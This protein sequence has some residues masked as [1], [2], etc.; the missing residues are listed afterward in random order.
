VGI[1]RKFHIGIEILSVAGTR[2]SYKIPAAALKTSLKRKV[3]KCKKKGVLYMGIKKQWKKTAASL[4]VL[5]AL[6]A[7]SACAVQPDGVKDPKYPPLAGEF[8]PTT[9]QQH[10]KSMTNPYAHAR[11]VPFQG[12]ALDVFLQTNM[13]TQI[14]FPAPPVLVNIGRPE[15]FSVEVV[16]EFNSVFVKPNAEVEMTNLIVTTERGIY[17]FILKANPW[18][19]FDI[20]L[21]VTDPYRNVTVD[22]TQTLLWMAYNGVRPP[23]FQF[24]AMEIR[25]IGDSQYVY[26]P[27]T[28]TGLR[29][30]LKRSVALPRA[31]KSVHWIEFANA[32]H[33]DIRSDSNAASFMIDERSVWTPGLVETA[34]P[35]TQTSG[36]PLL[37]KGEKVDM[38]LITNQGEVP[39]QLVVRCM[40]QGGNG[41]FPLEAR[42]A[43]SV[44]K[45]GSAGVTKGGGVVV[46]GAQ[47]VDE[48][49]QK[50]YEEQMKKTNGPV[51]PAPGSAHT[52]VEKTAQGAVP[53]QPAQPAQPVNGA[54]GSQT[55]DKIFFVKP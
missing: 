14:Q 46:P 28:K 26:D 2:A 21:V 30:T 29:A 12:A 33:P 37:G 36:V 15:G 18:K 54:P 32:T 5:S 4:V 7:S 39:P 25:N 47:T 6:F 44:G 11:T 48:R 51:T 27:M 17:T 52:G 1:L 55:G 13:V 10:P 22:D 23:E 42:F 35:G 43:T 31:S 50:M 16:P 45:K 8:Y 34:V 38:F 3:R 20:R 41:D 24:S 49:L 19:S 40:M 9:P 53:Q